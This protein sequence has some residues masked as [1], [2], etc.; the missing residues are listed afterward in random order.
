MKSPTQKTL[1]HYRELGFICDIAEHWQHHAKRR[2]DLF[3]FIDV[4]AVG[5]GRIIA[6]QATAWSGVSARVNKIQEIEA[7]DEWLLGGGEIHVI[8]WKP[9]RSQD[10]RIVEFEAPDS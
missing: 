4:V 10:F 9:K 7:A 8:G 1:K 5:N 6:I 2:K 3:N